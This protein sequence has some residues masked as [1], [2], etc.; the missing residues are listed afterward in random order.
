MQNATVDGTPVTRGEI[1][2][3]GKV[4]QHCAKTRDVFV[5]YWQPMTNIGNHP[6]FIMWVEEQKELWMKMLKEPPDAEAMDKLF[7]LVLSTC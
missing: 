3:F 2:K 1:W 5:I 6:L 4:L 7:G